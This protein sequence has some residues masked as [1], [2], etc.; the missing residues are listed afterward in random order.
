MTEYIPILLPSLF[1]YGTAMF[2]NVGSQSGSNVSFRPPP[3]VFS[4]VWPVLY[5]M[6]GVSW[7]FARKSNELWSDIFYISL[8]MLL[9]LWIVLYSCQG[10]KKNAIYVL[11]LSIVFGLLCYTVADFTA[12]LLI[13]PLIGWL[14]FATILNIFEVQLIDK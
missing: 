14:L 12:K 11:V 4:I 7:Y 10:D 1:G 13:V 8:I 5:I 2:C 3:V 9:N 6:L